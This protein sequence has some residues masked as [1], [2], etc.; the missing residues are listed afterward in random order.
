MQLESQSLEILAAALKKME[1]GFA[2]LTGSEL[3]V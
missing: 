3:N 1:T 2:G